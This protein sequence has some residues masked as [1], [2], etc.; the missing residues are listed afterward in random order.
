MCKGCPYRTS[1]REGS[2]LGPEAAMLKEQADAFCNRGDESSVC[3]RL[4][5][6][7]SAQAP[8]L[9]IRRTIETIV[10]YY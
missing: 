5:P 1:K 7:Q 4:D 9:V 10:F 8:G 6:E 2:C 3:E